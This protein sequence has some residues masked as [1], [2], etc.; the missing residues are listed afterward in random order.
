MVLILPPQ[1]IYRVNEDAS[2]QMSKLQQLI[3]DGS[4]VEATSFADLMY[5][6]Q[7]LSARH[8]ELLGD[9]EITMNHSSQG[10][11]YERYL[12]V[13]DATAGVYY[14]NN[15]TAYF[16]EYLSSEPAGVLAV[17]V[18]SNQ[19][20]TVSLRVHLRRGPN[21]S[22][23]RWEDYSRK[24]GN[25]TIVIG[26][27]SASATGIEFAAGARVMAKG[28]S[29]YT[30][31]D[32]ILIDHADEAWIYFQSWTDFR[33]SDPKAAVLAD[34]AAIKQTYP[35]IRA[36]HVKDYQSY[37]HR[38][39]LSLG[40]SSAIQKSQTTAQ[41][42]GGLNNGTFD[43][44]L[45]A[46]YFDFGRYLFI[47]TSRNGTLPPNLQGIWNSQLDPFWGAKYTTNINLQMNYWPALV[48]NLADLTSPLHNLIDSIREKG[49]NVSETMY[50]V[51][52]GG[53]VSH[54][55]TDLWGDSA[56]Q[57]NYIYSTWWGSSGP[58]LVFHLM[59]YYRYTGD[60]DFLREHYP[61]LKSAALFYVGFLSDY[62]G[63][64]VVNPTISPENAYFPPNYNT[65]PVAITLGAT[66][67]TELLWEL[68]NGIQEANDLLRLGDESF[69]AQL[70][71]LK[72][73]FPP[74]RR[75]YY[76]GLQEWI[77]D[78]QE[79][80]PGIDHL[81]PLW[82]A[83]P[84]NE[85]TSSN[86]TLFN[87]ARETLNNRLLHGSAAGGWGASWCTALAGR[88]FMPD[89]ASH[90]L[91]HLIANQSQP[92]S[93]LNSGAPSEFQIDGNLGGPGALPELFMQSH[94]SIATT[95]APGYYGSGGSNGTL[96]AAFTGTV[97]KAPL[98]RL[99]PTVPSVFASTGG[100]GYFNGLLARGGFEVDVCWDAAGTLVSA[101]IASKLGGPAYVTLGQTPI[102][103]NNGTAIT[104]SGAGS[105]VF[106]RLDTRAGQSYTVKQA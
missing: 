74:Y 70:N 22:L 40:N 7:P 37:A 9:L 106:I 93:L 72:S 80:I 81:S 36:A 77:H 96:V 35:E 31:G 95:Q 82:A 18:A 19:T 14:V 54:H 23:N 8:Y 29:V 48:T 42:I 15:G 11:S 32:T 97:E 21:G 49:T 94:E 39:E 64:K 44:E 16:R 26:G 12:D 73:Q 79:A 66:M 105:G 50:G 1:F 75:N 89:W 102:G 41:R 3:R 24:S 17:R 30:L 103:K 67:D 56:P 25:D 78:Y 59:E 87:W 46:L 38:V 43:P 33:K 92:D 101:T 63:Y 2:S 69:V 55:N 86:S 83:Y 60:Q 62:E 47:S 88:Y 13:D 5:A 45:V 34:L 58:W 104:S 84:G 98:I 85:I 90:C 27:H 6:G 68:F 99:L 65:T 91:I 100:G 61:V 4:V 71:D 28:G 76:G 53:F 10:S 20:G 51:D 52:N 57:D